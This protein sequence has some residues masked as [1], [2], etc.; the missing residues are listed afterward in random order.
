V[1]LLS[2]GI[3]MFFM[4]E[5]IVAQQIYKYDNILSA[6]E[7]LRGER[8]G[9]GKGMFRYYQDLIRLRRQQ[10]SVRSRQIDILQAHDS[11]RLLA[12]TR[13]E[14]TNE[15]L[16]IASLNNQPFPGQHGPGGTMREWPNRNACSRQQHSRLSTPLNHPNL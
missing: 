15:L 3:P 1:A 16:I 13:R 2:P 8:N 6:R 5:E 4:G 14:S 9:N 11:N 12:F 7:D 10:P